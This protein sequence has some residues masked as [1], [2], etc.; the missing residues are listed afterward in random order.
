M[1][2]NVTRPAVDLAP[3]PARPGLALVLALLA[4]PAPRSPGNC[5]PAA[6]G[7]ACRWASLRSCSDSGHVAGA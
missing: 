5:P 3:D 6:S 2:G 7:S 4:S 1:E